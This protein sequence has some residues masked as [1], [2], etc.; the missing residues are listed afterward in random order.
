MSRAVVDEEREIEIVLMK[1][2]ADIDVDSPS[3]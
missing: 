1:K 3:I 2:K